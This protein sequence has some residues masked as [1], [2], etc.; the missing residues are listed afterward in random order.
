MKSLTD[1][2]LSIE[3]EA[4][5]DCGTPMTSGDSGQLSPREEM[6]SKTQSSFRP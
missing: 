1:L 6:L 4:Q 2:S 5:R 3:K